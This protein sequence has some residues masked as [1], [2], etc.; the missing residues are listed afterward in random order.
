[1]G[2][3]SGPPKHVVLQMAHGVAITAAQIRMLQHLEPEHR[4][5]V[6]EGMRAE[7]GPTTMHELIAM[8]ASVVSEHRLGWL[9]KN[10]YLGA[11][12]AYLVLTG[13]SYSDAEQLKKYIEIQAVAPHAAGVHR[14]TLHPDPAKPVPAPHVPSPH[15]KRAATKV[16]VLGVLGALA[17]VSIVA[18]KFVLLP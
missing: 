6:I 9:R 3:L 13:M 15:E 17:A 12:H 11:I 2:M 16:L 10:Q 14:G 8:A 5:T 1:M 18:T 4:A 7:G